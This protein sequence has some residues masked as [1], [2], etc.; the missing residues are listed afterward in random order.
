MVFDRIFGSRTTVTDLTIPG[1]LGPIQMRVYTPIGIK[2]PP[3]LVL[4]HGFVLRGN[5]DDHT[6]QVAARLASMGFL[7][8]LPT[9][10]GESRFEMRSTDLPVIRD[11]I[12]WTASTTHQR[13]AL[14]GVSFGGGL[15]IPAAAPP[16]IGKDVKLIFCMSGYNN[17]DS[18]GHYYIHDRVLDPDGKAYLGT[19]PPPGPLMIVSPYLKEMLPPQQAELLEPVI[20]RSIAGDSLQDLQLSPMATKEIEELQKANTPQIRDLYRAI[21]VNHHAEI[22]SISPASVL[23]NFNI[24][25]FVLHGSNDPILPEGEIEWMRREVAGNQNAHFLVSPWVSHARV[26]ERTS[27]WQKLRVLAFSANMLWH[28]SHREYLARSSKS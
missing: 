7:V 14:F 25:L 10:P 12:R 23:R 6:N 9:V 27:K 28:A 1:T 17:L 2:N 24:P 8:T 5:R 4:I 11:A 26:G 13:V 15:V 19:P 20:E 18:I 21:L 22:A 16:D 3:P